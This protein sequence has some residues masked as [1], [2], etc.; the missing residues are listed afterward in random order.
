MLGRLTRSQRRRRAT[1]FTVAALLGLIVGTGAQGGEPSVV[2]SDAKADEHGILI[3]EVTS[4]FQAAS[5]R[6]RVLLP[7]KLDRSKLYLVV[8]VLPVEKL[9]ENR[10]G[11]GLLEVRRLDLH[12]QY[13]AIFVAPTF[14]H[15]PWY[16]DHPTRPEIRQETYLLQVVLPFIEKTY[17]ARAAAAGRLLLGFSKSGWGALSLLLRHGDAFGKAAAWDAPLMKDKPNQFGMADIFGTQ[18][19]FSKYQISTL[20]E[21]QA[22]HFQ[23]G[24]RLILLGYGSFRKQHEDLHALME[25]LKIDHEYQDGPERKHIWE[26]GWLPEAVRLLL[27][28]EPGAE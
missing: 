8:Y 11:D 13:Q 21:K 14:S 7:D 23:H 25:R 5:T 16:A 20:L 10:Y 2:I 9:D 4:P 22:A 28:G 15:L 1:R 6:I 3:H 24:K 17:P 12:N 26:S 19:N 18:E 27:S